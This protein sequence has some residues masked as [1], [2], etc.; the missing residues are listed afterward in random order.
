MAF[1]SVT[2]SA[3]ATVGRT[4]ASTIATMMATQCQW[5]KHLIELLLS[6]GLHY[7]ERTSLSARRPSA[8]AVPGR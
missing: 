7:D 5:V 2:V 4:G 1:Q 3:L 8:A 6:L